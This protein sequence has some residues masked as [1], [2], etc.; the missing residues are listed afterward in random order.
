MLVFVTVVTT[1][2]ATVNSLDRLGMA[3]VDLYQ[4][5]Y[6]SKWY[7]GGEAALA[8]GLARARERGLCRHIGV[9]NMNGAQVRPCS[10]TTLNRC[11]I[12]F[13]L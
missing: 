11:H 5:H 2:I 6:P 8:E 7:I 13:V 4:L 1:T 3:Y 12:L 9:C 10:T